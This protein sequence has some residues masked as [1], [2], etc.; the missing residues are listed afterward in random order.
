M[1]NPAEFRLTNEKGQPMNP[2]FD[3]FDPL[4]PQT[5]QPEERVQP[6]REIEVFSMDKNA[7]LYDF[8]PTAEEIPE[9]LP[10]ALS[11]VEPADSS[12]LPTQMEIDF[13]APPEN[14]APPTAAKVNIQPKPLKS[15]TPTSS[16]KTS[17][18]S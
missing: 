9:P 13:S 3:P 16:S 2:A 1:T 6:V 12:T 10:K 7:D 8:R 5:R 14:P 11:A 17:A 18:G 4:A 15:G